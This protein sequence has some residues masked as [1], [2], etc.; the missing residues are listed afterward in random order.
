MYRVNLRHRNIPSILH[1]LSEISKSNVLHICVTM[2]CDAAMEMGWN[3]ILELS[4]RQHI[5]NK[6]SSRRIITE[7]KLDR[8]C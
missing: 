2:K 4:L 7:V 6:G 1:H 5:D 3:Q 8:T